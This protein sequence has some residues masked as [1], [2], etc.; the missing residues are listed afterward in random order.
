[1]AH[2]RGGDVGVMLIATKDWGWGR[3]CM[4]I[5]VHNFDAPH[6]FFGNGIYTLLQ[7]TMRYIS[8]G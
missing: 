2:Y 4:E 6:K 8:C 1:M 5:N 3:G 7:T